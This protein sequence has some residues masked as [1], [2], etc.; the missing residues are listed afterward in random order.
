LIL[1]GHPQHQ[2]GD[3]QLADG[4]SQ[5][6]EAR[7]EPTSPLEKM[8]ARLGTGLGTTLLLVAAIA[9]G[10]AIGICQPLCELKHVPS[11]C[12]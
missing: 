5:T 1:E 6:I 7:R 8:L 4:K 11:A 2:Q 12:A 9:L 3:G 10:A